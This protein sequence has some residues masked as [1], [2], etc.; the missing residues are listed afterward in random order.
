MGIDI[1]Q[2]IERDHQDLLRGL[3]ELASAD[4]SPDE[5]R[6]TLDGLRLLASAHAEAQ[7]AVLHRVLRT[8]TTPDHLEFLVAQVAAAHRH[9]ERTL[10]AMA[11][12][13]REMCR[14]LATSL[15][16][17]MR[18]HHWHEQ[19]A[20]MPALRECLSALRYQALAGEYATARLCHVTQIASATA[21]DYAR[22]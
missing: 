18:Q 4:T 5:A 6:S 9:H 16:E 2:L 7:A 20:L 19:A 8:M 17:A 15:R 13:S 21:Y 1:R 12:A 22:A 11:G 3:D 10:D 14:M